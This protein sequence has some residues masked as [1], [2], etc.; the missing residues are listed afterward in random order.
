MSIRA[1]IAAI[2]CLGVAVSQASAQAT[3]QIE[4]PAG[5][6]STALLELAKQTGTDL[7]YPP[8]QV[9]GL[10]T[11]GAHGELTTTQ[12]VMQLLQ[13]TNLRLTV[14]TTGA[15]FIAAPGSR[16]RAGAKSQREWKNP[17]RAATEPTV[18]PPSEFDEFDEVE[19]EPVGLPEI[20]V[21]GEHSLNGDIARSE[22]DIRPYVVFESD[23]IQRSQATSIEEFLRSR[24][25]M[26][27]QA[28]ALSQ[29]DLSSGDTRSSINLRGLGENQTLILVD[30]RRLPSVATQYGAFEQPDINGIPLASVERIEVLPSSASG[31]YGG[32]ATGG[33]V[34]IILKRDY[35]GFGI[36]VTY[37]NT[38]DTVAANRRVD[39][40]GGIS[41]FEGRTRLNFI[42]SHADSQDLLAGQ[43]NFARRARAQALANNPSYDGSDGLPA[44]STPNVASTD[45]TDLVLK[46]GTN[47]GSP[48]TFVPV[49]YAG[50]DG[51][52][53]LVSNAGRFNPAISNDL[54]GN[55]ASLV[56]EPTLDSVSVTLRQE[57]NEHI[58]AY[59]D[60]SSNNNRGRT[61]AASFR[62]F[63]T[64]QQDAPNNPFDQDVN[65]SF[66]TDALSN[67]TNRS[68]S[69]TLQAT[70]GLIAR[71][72][73][74]WS[75]N[76]NYGWSRARL[77]YEITDPVLDT[78]AQ[79]SLETGVSPDGV[80]PA[81][82]VLQGSPLDF[83]PYLTYLSQSRGVDGPNDNILRTGQLRLA[84]P[85][86]ELPGGPAVLSA[87]FERRKEVA[88]QA[89]STRLDGSDGSLY[90]FYTPGRSQDVDSIYLESTVPV[91]SDKNARSWLHTLELQLSARRDE[92]RTNSARA[93]FQVLFERTPAEGLVYAT[94]RVSSTDVALGFRMAPAEDVVFRASYGT[95]FLPPDISQIVTEFEEIP[96]GEY[97]GE[98]DPW[99]GGEKS[100][101]G[102][103]EGEEIGTT[104]GA[105]GDLLFHAVR[106]GR[107]GN[108]GLHPEK[109]RSW[110][111]GLIL[112]PRFAPGFRLSL[113]YTEIT[114]RN[115][116]SQFETSF[117]LLH[118]DEFP[119]L[120]VRDP[121]LR[122]PGDPADW[123]DPI[124]AVN[125]IPVNVSRSLAEAYDAQ[126]EYFVDLDRFGSLQFSAVA[127]LQKALLLTPAPGEAPIS[128]V[129]FDVQK[130]GGNAALNWSH[131]PWAASWTTEYV[132][133]YCLLEHCE[134][135]A[136]Q[137][138]AVIRSV[139]Y[140]DASF[141]YQFDDS[142]TALH[143]IFAN[144]S[145]LIGVKNVFNTEPPILADLFGAGGGYSARGAGSDPRLRRFSLTFRK[146]F[147]GSDD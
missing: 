107:L 46:D 89:F 67:F 122:Q 43:R 28:E 102:P 136:N 130:W 91:V 6:L 92:Y 112:T 114:K 66:A 119:G 139:L 4:I 98:R 17:G 141:A 86:L 96:A 53:A 41:F 49:G 13:G 22:D 35:T 33:V 74:D 126:L 147:G 115:E 84:G 85:W 76:A 83:S 129:N 32:G 62:N 99:R 137:G 105:G 94:N 34:N 50:T 95:G 101:G 16:A 116:I 57:F 125:E 23:D 27:M 80:R 45:G 51:G 64:L 68:K 37:G 71:L 142:S 8:E 113:D 134:R 12:A 81:L 97:S 93:P 26:N 72:P 75:L 1:T 88:P 133:S 18:A 118:E 124:A 36:G 56:N 31:I 73:Y 48:K 117:I 2:L 14:D 106:W 121:A 108:P 9:R 24:L 44:S 103:D 69:G 10:T 70:G 135:D 110:S 143:G 5:D 138:S 38:F 145:V 7:I 40:S 131:G 52:A 78:A 59:L 21:R 3:K 30:G 29:S 65:V 87:L 79:T 39:L 128:R 140:H 144:T 19:L 123:R 90:Y 42:A 54:F 63:V 100:G 61:R 132:H 58:D 60:F 11:K 20:L 47:L 15:I 111:A 104:R 55:R 120:V 77:T 127:T 25:P 109:S 146:D 82:N